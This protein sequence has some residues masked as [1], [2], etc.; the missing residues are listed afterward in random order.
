LN[1]AEGNGF[2]NGAAAQPR[3]PGAPRSVHLSDTQFA[4]LELIRYGRILASRWWLI[5]GATILIGGYVGIRDK[6]FSVKWYRAQATITPVTP[7]ESMASSMGMGSSMS[8]LGGGALSLLDLGGESSNAGIAEQYM[9]IMNSYAFTTDLIKRYNLTRKIE[10]LSA[11]HLPHLTPWKLHKAIT[12]RFD[13]SF[14][15]KSGNLT[16]YFVDPDPELAQKILGYYLTSLRDK[17]R[18]AE[19]QSAAAAV[20]SLEAEIGKTPDALLQNQLYE[21]VARQ[22]QREKLAQV[23][24]DFAYKVIEPPVVPDQYYAPHARRDAELTGAIVF[25]L[26]A[27]GVLMWE[28]IKGARE[29]YLALMD[30][31]RP[32]EPAGGEPAAEPLRPVLSRRAGSAPP[33]DS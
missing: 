3:S 28:F 13:T 24:A 15:Y 23:E 20:A 5:L 26:L 9:A 4:M 30:S 11:G 2:A 19:V 32:A 1:K 18:N 7:E 6:Y 31:K 27:G 16:L 8:G 25:V 21:L 33:R 10:P 22:I 17:V 12:S 29:D 14:D